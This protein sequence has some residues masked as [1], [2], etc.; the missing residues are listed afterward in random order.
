MMRAGLVRRCADADSPG[1]GASS[2]A[3][4]KDRS[5]QVGTKLNPEC[6]SFS[7]SENHDAS[8]GTQIVEIRTETY[9][10]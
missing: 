10:T 7:F 3:D 4:L 5:R 9:L 2:R 6:F 8:A 1:P